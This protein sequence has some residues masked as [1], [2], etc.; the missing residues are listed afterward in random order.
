MA[1]QKRK[2]I[3]IPKE[4]RVFS[5]AEII[6]AAR[7]SKSQEKFAAELRVSQGTLSKYEKN[8]VSPPRDIIE[9]CMHVL[10]N[11]QQKS[12]PIM[13]LMNEQLGRNLHELGDVKLHAALN[14]LVD[15]LNRATTHSLPSRKAPP[16]TP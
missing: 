13:R 12:D 3:H 8:E 7:A 16:S 6:T 14:Y 10:H 5:V 9:Y 4:S 1:K 11:E 15:Y 2:P